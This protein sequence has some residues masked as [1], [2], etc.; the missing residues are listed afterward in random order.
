MREKHF[1]REFDEIRIDSLNGDKYRTGKV[2]PEG[3]PDP[4]IFSTPG[5]PVGIQVGTAITTLVRKSEHRPT[6]EVS[7]RSLWG[8]AKREALAETASSIP[9][10]L[11]SNFEPNLQLGLP[12]APIAASVDCTNGQLYQSCFTLRSLESIPAAIDSCWMLT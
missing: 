11:Y 12:F 2:T 4:S 5:D 10:A 3:E 7:F 6:K 1:L 8:Q 9:D